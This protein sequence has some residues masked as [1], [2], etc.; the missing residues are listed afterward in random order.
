MTPATAKGEATRSFLLHTA[1]QIFGEHGYTATTMAELINA[2]GLTKGAF[3]FYFRSKADLALAVL[4]DQQTRWLTQVQLQVLAEPNSG[5]QLRALVP[6]MLHLIDEDPGAWSIMRLTKELVADPIVATRAGKHMADWV[7]FVADIVR[8]GQADG[9]LRRGLDPHAVAAVLVG[10]FDGLKTITDA[11]RGGADRA[12]HTASFHQRA[13][14]LLA[15][16][17]LA[18]ILPA[19]RP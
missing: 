7:D 13:E 15:L 17:E 5:A 11:L 12:E 9:D 14:A 8:R 1:A 2:S 19:T 16:V 3:Y 18:L 10:S 6:V 4:E